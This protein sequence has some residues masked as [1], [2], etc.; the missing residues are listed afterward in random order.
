MAPCMRN[1]LNIPRARKFYTIQCQQ[2]IST[3]YFFLRNEQHNPIIIYL[4]ICFFLRNHYFN[5][6][7]KK[8]YSFLSLEKL[9]KCHVFAKTFAWFNFCGFSKTLVYL[10]I[11]EN[12]Q[13]ILDNT[14]H[15]QI[16]QC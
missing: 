1:V 10:I 6:F 5:S 9:S 3:L 2:N 7:L 11:K 15:L 14:V 13:N 16:V 4:V 8:L 12:A